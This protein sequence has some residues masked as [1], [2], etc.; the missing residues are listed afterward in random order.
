M[1]HVSD[2]MRDYLAA[3]IEEDAQKNRDHIEWLDLN[4]QEPDREL[5]RAECERALALAS[6]A[7]AA[8]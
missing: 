5:Q 2:E 8:I 7:A 4:P 3:L 1:T 6:E